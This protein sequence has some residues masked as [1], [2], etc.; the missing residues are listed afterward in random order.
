MSKVVIVGGHGKVALLAAPLLVEAAHEVRSLVRNPDQCDEVAET[1]AGPEVADVESMSSA[2]LVDLLR[3]VDTVVWSAGAGGGS[4]ERTY[5]VDRDAAIKTMDAA[6][7]ANVSHFVM[8]SYFGASLDH[9]VPEDNPFFHYAQAKGQADQH[10]RDSSL[11]WT[12]L[13]PSALTLD[14]ATG[15]IDAT[16]TAAEQVSRGN[17]ARVIETVV[18]AE[19]AEVVG[20]EISFNDGKTPV[21][22]A[23][24][25]A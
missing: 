13:M 22:E 23:I 6:Q 4:P 1:G 11:N 20:R 18:S 19:P 8:V 5:A 14:E 24:T 16:A 9:G 17:V 15:E 10:L 12:L 2:D 21:R 7:E 25:G 3:G